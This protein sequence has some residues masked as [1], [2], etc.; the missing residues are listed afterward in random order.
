MS[1]VLERKVW[2][3]G[4]GYTFAATSLLAFVLVLL[5]PRILFQELMVWIPLQACFWATISMYPPSTAWQI[6][7][8]LIA[9][10]PPVDAGP[11]HLCSSLPLFY[12]GVGRLRRVG[13][14]GSIRLA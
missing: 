3:T 7:W 13:L 5:F 8:P 14:C 4:V 12:L 1:K 10:T 6:A 9:F 2:E 11:Q